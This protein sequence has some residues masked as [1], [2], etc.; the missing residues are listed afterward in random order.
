MKTFTFVQKN[1]SAIIVL[2]AP[3]FDEAEVL[4][5]EEVKDVYGWRVDDEEGEDEEE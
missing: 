2:S 5:A 4:L 3:N 1:S